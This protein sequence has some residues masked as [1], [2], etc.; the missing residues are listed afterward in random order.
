MEIMLVLEH[1]FCMDADG[2]VWCNR[3]VD[4]E[5][6]KRYLQTFNKVYVCARMQKARVADKSWK[7]ASGI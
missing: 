5:Y 3:V 2:T 4:Y 1:H 7:K 6:L